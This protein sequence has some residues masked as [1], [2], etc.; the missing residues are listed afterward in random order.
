MGDENQGSQSI[1]EIHFREFEE[2][3]SVESVDKRSKEN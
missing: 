3:G 2:F 1:K